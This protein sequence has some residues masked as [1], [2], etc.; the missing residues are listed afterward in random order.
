[1]ISG[2][3]DPC[4]QLFRQLNIPPLQSQYIFSL[5]LYIKN[6]DQFISNSEVRDVNTRCTSNLH[7]PLAD[8]ILYQKESFVQEIG[9]IITCLQLSR[10]YQ[11]MGNV[12]KQL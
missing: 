1:M 10:T 4:C 5:L 2:R 7:I 9:F 12:L 8:V 11:M 6:R 3:R